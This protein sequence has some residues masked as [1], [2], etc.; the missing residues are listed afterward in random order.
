[1]QVRFS[2]NAAALAPLRQL[3]SAH[4][5]ECEDVSELLK[6]Y[7]HA[8][9]NVQPPQHGGSRTKGKRLNLTDDERAARSQRAAEA[10]ARKQ[11]KA[12]G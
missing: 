11:P 7:L 9:A 10:R 4:G 2:V 12:G 8:L 6:R 3:A 5:I 1:M